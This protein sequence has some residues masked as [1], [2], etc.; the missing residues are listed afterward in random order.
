MWKRTPGEVWNEPWPYPGHRGKAHRTEEIT[1]SLTFVL[2]RLDS[3]RSAPYRRKTNGNLQIVNLPWTPL[4]TLGWQHHHNNNA[5]QVAATVHELRRDNLSPG[6]ARPNGS[7]FQTQPTVG[8]TTP[9]QHPPRTPS[10]PSNPLPPSSQRF[11]DESCGRTPHAR[12]DDHSL[13]SPKS[14]DVPA[15]QNLRQPDGPVAPRHTRLRRTTCL[16]GAPAY[17]VALQSCR[18]KQRRAAQGVYCV[19]FTL[20]CPHTGVEECS[21][22][23]NHVCNIALSG[24]KKPD[25]LFKNPER[26]SRRIPEAASGSPG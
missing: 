18:C 24:V 13:Q 17:I 7:P 11:Q 14:R 21:L 25:L 6:I 16:V 23:Q 2:L 22:A 15:N 4:R 20:C 3:P 5:V 1:A 10:H 8:R 9:S 12:L 26:S 19:F